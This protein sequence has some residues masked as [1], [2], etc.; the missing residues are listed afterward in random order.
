LRQHPTWD[1][2]LLVGDKTENV[3]GDRS[4]YGG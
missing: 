1:N 2:L 4:I 3:L